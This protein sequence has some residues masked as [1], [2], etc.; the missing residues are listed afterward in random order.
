MAETSAKKLNGAG[1][2][3]LW[4]RIKALV[5]KN[6]IHYLQMTGTAAVTASPYYAS[7]WVGTDSTITSL[8]TGLT[9]QVKVPVAGNG[10]Y[11]TV[12]DINGLGEHP[13]CANVSTMIGTRYAVGC[14]VTLV[15]DA[16]QSASVYMNGDAAQSV[17][18]VWKMADYNTDENDNS[19]GYYIKLEDQALPLSD[20]CYRYRLLFTSADGTKIVPSNTSTSTSATSAKTVNTRPID[21][22]GPIYVYYY[23]SNYNAG[24]KVASA[25]L[26]SQRGFALGYAFNTAG[27]TLAMTANAPVYLKCTPQA[28]G[29]AVMVDITQALP[30]TEDG[31]IYILLGYA[32]DATTLGLIL[33]HPV[34]WYHKGKLRPYTGAEDI[35][36]EERLKLIGPV[37]TC[38]PTGSFGKNTL[39]TCAGET[40]LSKAALTGIPDHIVVSDDNEI[41]VAD[42]GEVVTC[43]SNTVTNWVK[44]AG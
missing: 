12:L 19:V 15:Y 43:G 33:Q 44:I 17:T 2:S 18:G 23:T 27:G 31:Y 42:D 8:Y 41:I 40:Y 35:V 36:E 24:S 16:D 29:S 37:E 28:D 7:K 39:I 5:N 20:R 38:S 34:Y 21:P 32:Y 30:T 11:G 22:F 26:H 14:I 3:T 9:V 13:V 6:R 1:L 4:N 25:R 10:T